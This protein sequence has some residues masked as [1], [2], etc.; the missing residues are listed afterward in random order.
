MGDKIRNRAQYNMQ[1]KY[2]AET[3]KMSTTHTTTANKH[4]TT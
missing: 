3:L 2:T 1:K 4:K